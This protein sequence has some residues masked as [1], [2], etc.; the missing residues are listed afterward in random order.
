MLPKWGGP[1][2]NEQYVLQTAKEAADATDG[3]HETL[4]RLNGGNLPWTVLEGK[5]CFDWLPF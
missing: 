3:P 5:V 1:L 4:K 2:W